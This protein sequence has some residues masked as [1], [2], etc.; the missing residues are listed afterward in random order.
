MPYSKG[1]YAGTITGYNFEPLFLAIIKAKLISSQE[2]CAEIG[3]SRTH[4]LRVRSGNLK[5]MG[6]LTL[7]KMQRW[8][9]ESKH[10]LKNSKDLLLLKAWHEEFGEQ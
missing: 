4:W 7:A 3:I 9:S 5:G 8:V 6:T 1:P 2:A 10:L